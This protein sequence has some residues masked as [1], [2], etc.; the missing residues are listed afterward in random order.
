MEES[1]WFQF[2]HP[3]GV[4]PGV[5]LQVTLDSRVSIHAPGRGATSE[6][7]YPLGR[8]QSFNSRTREGC[9]YEIGGRSTSRC[10]FNSRTREGCDACAS[11]RPLQ[12][13]LFQFT[14]PGG[15]RRSPRKRGGLIGRFQFTH[16]GGVR[17][18]ALPC[19][20]ADI[21]VSIHAPGRGATISIS[22]L[23]AIHSFQ[24]T[25]PG[26]VRQLLS[27]G[28]SRSQTVSIHAPGRGATQ[29]V[30]I[31]D[32]LTLVSIHAPG[33]GATVVLAQACGA[34]QF[35]FTHPGG[36]RRDVYPH[37]LPLT[38]VSIHAPGRG[39][40]QVDSP[41]NST[42]TCFNSRTREGCDADNGEM[43][44]VA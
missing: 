5:S 4:R 18:V 25:H 41:S 1:Q 26:G 13:T 44:G 19:S 7:A 43:C 35:Q 29:A 17:R 24:F 3:G 14:H 36:V 32:G 6:L 9:D 34:P 10:S 42:E 37:A 30:D 12:G 27:A 33:R 31:P 22:R 20:R 11:C 28:V 2:T 16:P 21:S 8:A 39:A 23:I 40:T 38:L 15:V